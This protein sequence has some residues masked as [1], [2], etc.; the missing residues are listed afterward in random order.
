MSETINVQP[1][2]DRAIYIS[3]GHKIDT[4]IHTKI[5]A[6]VRYLEN[7]PF[8]G[9][10]ECVP[11]YT[12]VTIHYDPLA[13]LQKHAIRKRSS[14][15]YS[16]FEIASNYVKEALQRFEEEEVTF[17]P[18][19]VTIPVVYGGAY[20]PDLSIVAK[21]NDLTEE[22]VI[23]RHSERE[24]T[25]FMLGF[26]P[27]FPF[28]GGMDPSI[29]TPRKEN[30]RLTIPSGSVGIA[31]EQTGIYP[32]ETPGGWQIIGRTPVELFLPEQSP[33]TFLLPGDCIR[34]QPINAEQYEQW[35][36]ENR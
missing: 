3:F 27:G 32:L 31:G 25:V 21:L 15:L 30:P 2:G 35:K 36:E 5:Q 1:F 11:A 24:Y 7:H 16:P 28:L 6:F 33:P 10:L 20:G 13:V 34:F 23:R 18:R 22:E 9:M 8:D 14:F 4:S 12:N 26:A 29:A 19:T 17:T